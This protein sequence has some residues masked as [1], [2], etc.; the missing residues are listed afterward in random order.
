MRRRL[1][2][3]GASGIGKSRKIGDAL[4][5]DLARAGGFLTV[6][7]RNLEG[8]P[9]RFCL[10]STDRREQQ[11]FLDFTR[12]GN[13]AD[14]SVFRTMGVE[15]LQTALR[16]PFAVLDEIGGIE[17]LVPE[18]SEAL[19]E[20]LT[21]GTPC[22]GVMKGFAPASRLMERMGLGEEYVKAHRALYERLQKDPETL[23]LDLGGK[24]EGD[25]A[26]RIAGWV[27]EYIHE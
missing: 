26:R 19:D 14:L 2:L 6:R 25:A 16:C 3:T 13:P 8:K 11:A 7:E 27:E 12:S 23:M 15:L 18:F 4:G 20:F 24:R 21:S 9:Q 1:F 5:D 17:L 22:I 10:C